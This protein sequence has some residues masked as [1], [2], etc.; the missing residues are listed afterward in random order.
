MTVYHGRTGEILYR[1]LAELRPDGKG[2]LNIDDPG[3]YSGWDGEKMIL[4][5]ERTL[6]PVK[7]MR[8]RN[9]RVDRAAV[10]PIGS[11]LPKLQ[12]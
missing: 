5:D 12:A 2:H 6:E 1:G 3:S 4:S 11:W 9:Y 7:R 8:Q 10:A